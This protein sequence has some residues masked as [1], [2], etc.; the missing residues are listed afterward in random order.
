MTCHYIVQIRMVI[1]PINI[2]V[3]ITV[4]YGMPSVFRR[5]EYVIRPDTRYTAPAKD[6]RREERRPQFVI[7]L[8]KKNLP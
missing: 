4:Y 8:H 7:V 1:I 3:I 2:P 5:A 6:D